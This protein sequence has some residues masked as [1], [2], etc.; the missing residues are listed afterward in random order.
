MSAIL[1]LRGLL[2][3]PL[4]EIEELYYINNN[5]QHVVSEL[6]HENSLL[7]RISCGNLKF[8]VLSLIL[9]MIFSRQNLMSH[10]KSKLTIRLQLPPLFINQ[11]THLAIVKPVF[12]SSKFHAEECFTFLQVVPTFVSILDHCELHV[13][14]ICILSSIVKISPPTCFFILLEFVLVTLF[15]GFTP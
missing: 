5:K 14:I 11:T 10:M 15:K 1:T 12:F 9:I 2:F 7:E 13:P 4:D 8:K 3:T 6:M